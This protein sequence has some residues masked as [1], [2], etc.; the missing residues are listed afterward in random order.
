M[1]TFTE[2]LSTND[3]LYLAKKGTIDSLNIINELIDE[4]KAGIYSKIF[5]I[6]ALIFGILPSIYPN[7]FNPFTLLILV[8]ILL[9]MLIIPDRDFYRRRRNL[10]KHQNKIKKGLNY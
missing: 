3:P 4:N 2:S 6:T 7:F 1:D 8:N 9:A 10:A 5:Y